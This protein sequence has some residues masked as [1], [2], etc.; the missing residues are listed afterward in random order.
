M[1]NFFKAYQNLAKPD[2]KISVEDRDIYASRIYDLWIE[3]DYKHETLFLAI[4]IFDRILS[5]TIKV[6]TCSDLILYAVTSLLIAAK[7]E[8]PLSPSIGRMVKLL[9]PQEQLIASKV[10]I[11]AFE[12][13]VLNMLDFEFN[14]ISPL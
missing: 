13:Q 10:A 2:I 11:I 3:K 12:E 14:L 7:Q 4:N 6:V 5:K 8:Q 9:K 1:P